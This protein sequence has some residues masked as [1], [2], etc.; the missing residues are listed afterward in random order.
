[1]QQAVEALDTATTLAS[2]SNPSTVGQSVTFT[3]RVTTDGTAVTTGSVQFRD[4]VTDL[5]APVALAADGTATSSSRTPR[6]WR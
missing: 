6:G 1:M 4:G 3:A 2:N 5:G